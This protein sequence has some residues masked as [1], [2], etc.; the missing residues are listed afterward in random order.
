VN[1]LGWL[2]QDEKFEE[3]WVG[4][5]AFLLSLV[6]QCDLPVLPGLVVSSSVL[7]E[8]FANLE[9]SSSLF[10]NLALLPNYLESNNYQAL[11]TLS[12][13][14]RRLVLD[15]DFLIDLQVEIFAETTQLNFPQLIIRPSLIIGQIPELGSHSLLNSQICACKPDEIT[16]AIKMVWAD[17]FAVKNLFYWHQQG[18]DLAQLKLAILIQPISNAIASGTVAISSQTAHIQ[19]NWGLGHS[20]S[21]GEVDP[22][23]YIVNLEL[24]DSTIESIGSKRRGYH[25]VTKTSSTNNTI[26]LEPYAPT[27]EQQQSILLSPPQLQTLTTLIKKLTNSHTKIEYLEWVLLPETNS[28]LG[29][30]MI[31]KANYHA[32]NLQ[33]KR[34]TQQDQQNIILRGIPAAIGEVTAEVFVSPSLNNCL[35]HLQAKTIL[36]TQSIEP[37]Q[38]NLLH[39]LA[40]IITEQGGQ[41]SHSAIIARELG[42]PAIVAAKNATSILQTGNLITLDGTQGIVLDP[43]IAKNS[44]TPKDKK[45]NQNTNLKSDQPRQLSQIPL[46]TKLLVTISQ[47]SSI[48][49]AKNL[50]VEGVGLLRSE[51]M[52]MRILSERPLQEWLQPQYKE[53]LLEYLIDVIGEFVQEFSPRPIYYRSLDFSLGQENQHNPQSRN[54]GTYAYLQDS[55]FFELELLALSNIMEQKQSNLKLVLPFVR[56][57]REWHFCKN[58][59]QQSGLPNYPNFQLWIMLEVPSLIFMLPEYIDAGVQGVAIGINDLTHLL[60]G[61]NREYNELSKHNLTGNFLAIEKAIAQ[62]IQTTKENRIPCSICLSDQ[63]GN[64]DFLDKLV[65]LGIN[66]ISVEPQSALKIHHEIIEAE[67]RLIEDV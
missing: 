25:L 8:F 32:P 60:L 55:S 1:N 56:S 46:A 18:I 10:S 33:E 49:Q 47:S 15:S 35:D 30:F 45:T 4:E 23:R 2:A 9:R 42:I 67:R 40:G 54:R 16:Q 65:R 48:E 66:M 24:E 39:N 59:V 14:S 3:A 7:Q 58:L 21:Q 63:S 38:I 31:T 37:Q 34:L 61:I 20:L 43:S 22:D 44:S 27:K 64:L 29:G 17:L 57:L 28:D 41:T 50:P 62:I 52:L 53:L 12:I 13:D 26:C 6:L 19:A 36:V 5:K 51:F 11:Q